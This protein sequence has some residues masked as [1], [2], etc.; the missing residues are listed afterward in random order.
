MDLMKFLPYTKTTI[1]TTKSP[2][3]AV[4]LLQGHLDSN[5]PFFEGDVNGYQFDIHRKMGRFERNSFVPII[6]GHIDC[7]SQGTEI[8][9]TIRL[10]LAVAAFLSCFLAGVLYTIIRNVL[11]LNFLPLVVVGVILLMGLLFSQIYSSETD[12]ATK[13]LTRLFS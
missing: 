10:H 6:K 3:E 12:Q 4:K 5:A 9:M 8:R 7:H 11:H 1:L 13:V 2:N